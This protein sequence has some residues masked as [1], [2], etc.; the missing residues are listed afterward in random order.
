MTSPSA[1][2]LPTTRSVRS[3]H[4]PGLDRPAVSSRSASSINSAASASLSSTPRAT[5]ASR[6]SPPSPAPAKTPEGPPSPSSPTTP[7]DLFP[8][9]SQAPRPGPRLLLHVEVKRITHTLGAPC[10]DSETWVF[11]TS[12]TASQPKPI[13]PARRS[14]PHAPPPPAS[15][16][17]SPRWNFPTRKP[18]KPAHHLVASECPRNHERSPAA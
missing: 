1:A 8:N 14:N 4:R 17:Q 18:Q 16:G 5:P 11:T 3:S 15:S 6:V 2:T 13:H 7:T 9:P 12:S 10:L